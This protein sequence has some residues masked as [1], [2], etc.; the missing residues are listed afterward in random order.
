MKTP[1]PKRDSL[2]HRLRQSVNQKTERSEAD[3]RK[4]FLMFFVP[5][6]ILVFLNLIL[7]IVCV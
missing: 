5:L 6:Y 7:T 1:R 2:E 4:T 3:M